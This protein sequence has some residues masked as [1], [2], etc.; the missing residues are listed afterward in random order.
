MPVGRWA[1]LR[2]ERRGYVRPMVLPFRRRS[3]R[4][5]RLWRDEGVGHGRGARARVGDG[6]RGNL[7]VEV[8]GHGHQKVRLPAPPL[9]V[10]RLEGRRLRRVRVRSLPERVAGQEDLG[11]NR[12]VAVVVVAAK[13]R[14]V[15]ALAFEVG[16]PVPE[17]GGLVVVAYVG[18]DCGC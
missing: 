10:S 17:G 1:V 4:G 18:H 9:E 14:V 16:D 8:V 13:G 12:G 2:W 15:Q 5:D 6:V 7:A 11:G 3:D